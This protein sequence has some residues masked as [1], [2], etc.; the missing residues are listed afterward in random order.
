MLFTRTQRC[1]QFLVFITC[2]KVKPPLNK[3][4]AK[5]LI[6]LAILFSI[7]DSHSAEVI[8]YVNSPTN[9]D[10]QKSYYVTLLKLA[11]DKAEAKFS[12][13][14]LQA[15]GTTMVY[16]R[17]LKSLNEGK[18]D[19]M[20][21]MTSEQREQQALPIKIPIFKGLIGFRIMVIQDTKQEELTH[22]LST[23]QIKNMLA[24]QGHDWADTE[25]L[26]A[27]GFKVQT[28]DWYNSLYKGVSKG[29]YDYFPR[30]VLE[31]WAEMRRYQFKN[32]VV[33][34]KH[35]LYYPAAMY[36]FVQK[37]NEELAHRLDYGLNQA[38]NDGSFDKL[39]YSYPPHQ[40]ALS[41]ANLDSRVIHTL[42][43]PFLPKSTPL[44]D[45]RLWYQVK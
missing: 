5:L 7:N 34:N 42:T 3:T 13:I 10:Q 41:K 31:P 17:Q 45:T 36:F 33:E 32:L 37:G 44:T 23:Q 30:S 8:K 43:N 21:S 40:E 2:L 4:I 39:L 27:N 16:K 35:L 25:I 1:D 24:I 11:I 14:S 20:W 9:N 22:V 12:P 15:F 28:S 6:A 38:I 29:H 18:L 26:R 19:V